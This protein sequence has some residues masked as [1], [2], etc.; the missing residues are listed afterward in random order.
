MTNVHYNYY[1]CEN[2]GCGLRFPGPEGGLRGNRCP[3]C[4]THVRIVTTLKLEHDSREK[5]TRIPYMH[6]EAVFDNIRS[7]W[8]V[9]SMFRTADGVGIKKIYLCGFSPTPE[10]PQVGKTALG[11]QMV[12]P[13]EHLNNGFTKIKELKS[14]G[15]LL[16]ALEDLPSAIPLYDM[17]VEIINSPVVLVVGNE[18]CGVDPGILEVCDQV[19]YIPMVGRKQSYNVSVAFGI[20]ASYLLYC[21]IVAQGSFKKLPNT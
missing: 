6:L 21:Q 2:P 5:L 10:N 3:R 11:A 9:G 8:N 15:Y 20:A 19:I 7:A 16:W 14:Q 13:W 4:R 12:I 1:E 17:N 18:V